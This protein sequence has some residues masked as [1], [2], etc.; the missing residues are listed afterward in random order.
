MFLNNVLPCRLYRKETSSQ[1]HLD[2]EDLIMYV[3]VAI[4]SFISTNQLMVI[5]IKSL[6]M[7][8]ELKKLFS[9]WLPIL[10]LSPSV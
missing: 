3:R 8:D 4:L 10:M 1:H 5:L 6:Y 2:A 7:D 9:L